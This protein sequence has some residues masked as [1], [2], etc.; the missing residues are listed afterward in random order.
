MI[1]LRPCREQDA[2]ELFPLFSNSEVIQ[3][4]NFKRY[5]TL[6][7]LRVFLHDFLLIGHNLPLQYGPYVILNHQGVIGLCGLQQ[8]SHVEG[9][10]ELWYLIDQAFWQR[11]IAT[12]V[13]TRLM[14]LAHLNQA[15]R[16]IYANALTINTASWRILEKVGFN[17]VEE[18]LN[19]FQ[20]DDFK[21]DLRL[22]EFHFD[23]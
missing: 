4:T 6:E 21:A 16:C 14:E 5:E 22:Y 12:E 7:S 19:G 9:S 11:G 10:A 20:K 13:V 23:Q 17:L 8:T 15:L 3:Y 1:T 18:R 2:T